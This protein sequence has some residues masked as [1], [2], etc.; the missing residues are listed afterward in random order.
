MAGSI[1]KYETKQGIRYMVMLEVGTDG[2][3]KQKKKKGFKT[4]KDAN[5][6]LAENQTALNK[7]TYIEPSKMRY[8]DYLE[9]WFKI[10]KNSLGQQ[11]ISVSRG[12][13]DHWVIPN[14]GD[15]I[16]SSISPIQLEKFVSTL[17]E[18]GLAPA[19]IRGIFLLVK[20]SLTHA[21]E[22]EIIY[23]N[24]AAKIKLPSIDQ[25]EQLIWTVEEVKKFF[26]IAKDV[27]P[28]FY[29]SYYIAYYSGARQGEILG[30]PWANVNF[31]ENFIRIDQSLIDN[32]KKIVKK[33][34]NKSSKRIIGLPSFVMETLKQHKDLVLKQKN[35]LGDAYNDNNLVCCTSL[36]TPLCPTD[37]RKRM[38]KIAE[39]AKIPHMKFHGFRHLHAS[40][41]LTNG[42]N[43][44][45]ISKRLG[46]SS[47]KITL[48]VYSH[49]TEAMEKQV[50][51]SIENVTKAH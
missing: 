15:N 41:L 44:K 6:Y 2:K 47:P 51:D 7:G 24:P 39:I 10:K 19:T 23:K 1:H 36:G 49:V 20:N 18:S 32:G 25:A 38:K 22:S 46:H 48:D 37:I 4:K 28:S 21:V 35:K 11:T 27:N 14:L 9:D 45:M 3:R 16:I 30:L 31:D 13:L 12:N 5:A 8:A 40:T 50:I 33:V 17:I 29:I 42:I 34:K 26:E 43:V